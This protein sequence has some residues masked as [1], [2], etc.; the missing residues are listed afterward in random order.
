MKQLISLLALVLCVTTSLVGAE[1]TQRRIWLVVTRDIFTDELKPL[2]EKRRSDGFDVR[3]STLK[4][5]KAIASLKRR[6]SYILLVGDGG[7]AGKP[8]AWLVPSP[9]SKLY[10]W[11]QIQPKQFCADMLLGDFDN[12]LLPEAPVGRLPIRTPAQLRKIAAKIIAYESQKPSLNDL[13]LC[14]WAGAPG[15]N[16]LI[17]SMAASMA[18][19]SVR[20]ESPA[21]SSPWIILADA[22][23]PLCGSPR[24]QGVTFGAQLARG[25]AM[26]VLM[27]HGSKYG[28]FSMRSKQGD[29]WF[30]A[31]TASKTLSGDKP[32]PVMTIFSCDTGSFSG[33][34]ESLA[35]SLLLAS[36]GPVGVIAATTESHPLT[37]YFSGLSL[38]KSLGGPPQRLGDLWLEAQKKAQLARNPMIEGLLA[39]VE[40]KLEEKINVAKLRRDQM[41]MYAIL[42]DPATRMRTPQRLRGNIKYVDGAWKWRAN[43]PKDATLLHVGFRRGGLA[44]PTAPRNASAAD[45][46]KLRARANATLAFK[47]L[48][49]LGPN[50]A[51][52]GTLTGRGVLRL[53]AIGPNCIYVAA[54]KLTPPAKSPAAA[55]RSGKTHSDG[56][57]GQ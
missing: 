24:S 53:T 34:R 20:A 25:G 18:L 11:R 13:R 22:A 44:M 2:I 54:I 48:G 50:D 42:G 21:W 46:D 55:D 35:E 6:P 32:A 31:Q 8:A 51:W 29:V 1:P 45:R 41:L 19:T 3:V 23:H 49:R 39:D 43:R 47:P 27:G 17:D 15:Y 36:G 30:T 52:S 37:N 26:A 10:R 9:R 57:S 16:P 7:P 5:D 40:G 38:L 56:S 28:F 33:T 14:V 4:P 12:D